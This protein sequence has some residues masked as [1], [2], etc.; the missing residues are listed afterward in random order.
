[1]SN[2]LIAAKN[3]SRAAFSIATAGCALAGGKLTSMGVEYTSIDQLQKR[4]ADYKTFA[5]KVPAIMKFIRNA[6]KDRTSQRA[7]LRLGVKLLYE[8]VVLEKTIWP[9]RRV[10]STHHCVPAWRTSR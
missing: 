8:N 4:D 9:R 5:E 1:M 6:V 2:S 10:A 7:L 3:P